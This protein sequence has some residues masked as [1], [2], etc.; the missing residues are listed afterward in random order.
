MAGAGD[1]DSATAC[2]TGADDD[3]SVCR[4][5]HVSGGWFAAGRACPERKR[6]WLRAGV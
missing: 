3:V 5:T 4:T 1:A 6:G 2:L